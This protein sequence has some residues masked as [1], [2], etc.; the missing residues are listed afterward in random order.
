MGLAM[1]MILRRSDGRINTAGNPLHLLGFS[2][3]GSNGEDAKS[4]TQPA[5][6]P[7]ASGAALALRRTT[8]MRLGGF[9]SR[10]FLY[11]EDVDLSIACHQAGLK[12]LLEPRCSVAHDYNWGRN[13]EK[14]YLAERN[15]LAVI[16]TRYPFALIARL[17]PMIV[18]TELGALAFGGFPGARAA[19][20][21]G[22]LWLIRNVSWIRGRRQENFRRAT[23]PWGFLSH[24]TA[25]FDSS[26]PEAGIG[27]RVLNALL[28]SY[29]SA[30]RLS[31]LA[32]ARD[33]RRD[34]SE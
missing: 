29:A 16:L 33:Q 28:P 5:P 21:R 34:C 19:K 11:Q 14:I 4:F 12:V 9:P 26:A 30:T 7:A 22:Y 3:A 27:P 32:Q 15:R 1:P 31:R 25:R 10:F 8:W 13:P 24:T 17:A 18:L 6:V 2:W 23:N 20:V